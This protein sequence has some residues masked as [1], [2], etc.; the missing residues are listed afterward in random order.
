[1]PETKTEESIDTIDFSNVFIFSVGTFNNVLTL[2][3]HIKSMVEFQND[4][5]NIYAD[6]KLDHKDSKDD[7]DEVYK[8]FENFPYSLAKIKNLST[9]SDGTKLYGDYINVFKPVKN[10]LNDKLL[11]THSA[12]IYYNVTSKKTG[13]H[14]PAVLGSVAILPAGKLP[15]LME[16]FKPYMYESEIVD[17]S[18][19]I[20]FNDFI[21]F[22]SKLICNFGEEVLMTEKEYQ[23]KMKKYIDKSMKSKSFPDFLKMKEDEKDMYMKHMEEEY[24]RYIDED[25]KK[26]YKNNFKLEGLGMPEATQ[27]NDFSS[28]EKELNEIRA[29]RATYK[30]AMDAMVSQMKE[31]NEFYKKEFQAL[32]MKK[33]QDAVN[34]IVDVLINSNVPKLLPAQKSK[35]IF[36]LMGADDSKKVNYSIDGV[37]VEKSNFDLVVDLLNSLPENK[38]EFETESI[39]RSDSGISITDKEV[40]LANVSPESLLLDKQIRAK[41]A[42]KNLDVMSED[43]LIELYKIEGAIK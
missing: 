33:K 41:Y 8:I 21:D 40:S 34:S 5:A 43:E 23:N 16:V 19:I 37:D 25:K 35:A 28:V 11:T 4:H 20:N 12:E 22:E 3:K 6:L 38:Q 9:N 10:A 13:K 42:D 31:E 15:A 39:V 29:E 7:R 26:E 36:A 14:Y 27:S 18:N 2:S 24:A 1:M 32:Q 30:T 17:N